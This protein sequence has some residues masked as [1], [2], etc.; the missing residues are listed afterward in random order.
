[1]VISGPRR[2]KMKW[3]KLNELT[4]VFGRNLQPNCIV[5]DNSLFP[6]SH[7]VSYTIAAMGWFWG[8]SDKGTKDSDPLRNLDP[9]LKDFLKKEAPQKYEATETPAFQPEP[10]ETRLPV[11]EH[12]PKDES[13]PAVPSQSLYQDGRY[14]HLWKNYK[15]LEEVESEGKTDQERMQ[16]VLEGYKTRKAEIGKVALE[17][18]AIEQLEVSD[19]F[20]QGGWSAKTTMCRAESRK[21]ERCYTMQAV[22]EIFGTLD[23]AD[24]VLEIPES[25]GLPIII[26]SSGSL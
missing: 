2:G 12:Q 21:F 26:R 17:N 25:A 20:R 15:S 22:R 9:G 5:V 7:T 18:C 6:S 24:R 13:K 16:D 3:S 4:P 11:A 19:C 1:M 10:K 8:A 14:A 23:C